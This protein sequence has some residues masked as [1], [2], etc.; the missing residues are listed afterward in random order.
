MT[1]YLSRTN[2]G[3][4]NRRTMTWSFW[5]KFSRGAHASYASSE[6]AQQIY[7]DAQSGYPSHRISFHEGKAIF[8]SADDAPQNGKFAMESGDIRF[9]DPSAWYHFC[10]LYTSDAA[11]EEDSVDLGGRRIIKKK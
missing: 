7:G 11:D 9:R 2:S 3:A 8:Y 4:G 5:I 6:E 10:L 1:A